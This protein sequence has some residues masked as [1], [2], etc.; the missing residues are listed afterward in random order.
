MFHDYGYMVGMHTFW[1]FFWVVVVIAIVFWGRGDSWARRQRPRETPHEL[2]QRRL[3]N[4][5][6]SPEEY[7]KR[8]VILDRDS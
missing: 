1:W 2:L 5:E 4:G 8:K 3:A 7:E 6:I